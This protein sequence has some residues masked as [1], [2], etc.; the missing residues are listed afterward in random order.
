VKQRNVLRHHSDGIAQALLGDL[1]DVLAINEDAAGLNVVKALEQG[2]YGGFPGAG[3]ADQPDML[4]A[5]DVHIETVERGR[6]VRIGKCYV[7]QGNAGAAIHQGCGIGLIL[8]LVRHEQRR[9]RFRKASDVLRDI[10]ERHGQITR[11]MQYRKSER[12]DQ[13]D[14]TGAG[15]ATFPQC[16]GPPQES[17][18]QSYRDERMHN[19]Q[20]LQI[21]QALLACRYLPLDRGVETAMLVQQATE[22]LDDRH[23]AYDVR[24]LSVDGSSLIGKFM[25]QRF[26]RRRP[27]HH[28]NNHNT[29]N[30]HETECH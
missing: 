4:P 1:G 28:H 14:I 29:G 20:P 22:R 18:R 21:P 5:A 26:P 3:V 11:G 23:V 9:K 10:D 24:H 13:D 30:E 6:A 17:D 27:A 2:K 25:V 19:A 15:R 16:N 7:L 12:A 8:H